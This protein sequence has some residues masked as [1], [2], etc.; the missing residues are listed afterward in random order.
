[1]MEGGIC[2]NRPQIVVPE[3]TA[4]ILL[5]ARLQAGVIGKGRR[6]QGCLELGGD[7]LKVSCSGRS[8]GLAGRGP[9]TLSP[10]PLENRLCSQRRVQMSVKNN[11]FFMKRD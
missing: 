5:A 4:N 7:C 9:A 11:S 2:W 3:R 8:R 1:M 6:E 10:M